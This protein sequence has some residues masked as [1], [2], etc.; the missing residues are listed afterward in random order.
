MILFRHCDPRF[1]FLWESPAQ[2]PGRWNAEGEG[3]VHYL[4][5]TPAG[6]WAEFLR[7]E[8]IVD[9]ADLEGVAR[10][11]W[12][13]EIA[14]RRWAQ[15][16]LDAATLTGGVDSYPACQAEARRLRKREA[17][18]LRAPS[19]AL[20]PG[21]AHG[22]RVEQGEQRGRD[23]NGVVYVLFGPQPQLVGWPTVES[24]A[25]PARVLDL[26]RPLPV[27]RARN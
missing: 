11:L 19:A 12:A 20:G 17:R 10:G 22:W 7:H 3:P 6:A 2:P 1:P 25:P 5:D 26:V 23:R 24:G 9:A 15:P 13:V 4:A 27:H 18:A 16:R 14:P 8:G 21:K